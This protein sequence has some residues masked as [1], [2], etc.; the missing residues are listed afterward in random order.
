MTFNQSV[1]NETSNLSVSNRNI[2]HVA[3]PID[4]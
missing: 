1:S 4:A 2:K 3:N